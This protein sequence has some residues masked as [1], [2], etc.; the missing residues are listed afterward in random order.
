MEGSLDETGKVLEN[1]AA[2]GVGKARAK[3]DNVEYGSVLKAAVCTGVMCVVAES[4][5][6]GGIK[7]GTLL[8]EFEQAEVVLG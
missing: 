2:S 3:P 5:Y 8:H 7:G 6:H 4:L 1:G